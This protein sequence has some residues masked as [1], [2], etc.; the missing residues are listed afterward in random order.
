MS[1]L[2][3]V[4]ALFYILF[5]ELVCGLGR[6]NILEPRVESK[7]S[8][9]HNDVRESGRERERDSS[10]VYFTLDKV[11]NKIKCKI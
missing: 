9:P 10:R 11:E 7:A 4:D 2:L 6:G 3:M 1:A 5:S 8:A